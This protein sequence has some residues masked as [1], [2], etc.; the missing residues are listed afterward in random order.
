M[1][2]RFNA[3]KVYSGETVFGGCGGLETNKITILKRTKGWIIYKH[4]FINKVFRM[5]RN[6]TA[7]FGDCIHTRFDDFYAHSLEPTVEPF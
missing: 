1:A 6:Y 7:N 5:R 2:N 3:N 4:Q